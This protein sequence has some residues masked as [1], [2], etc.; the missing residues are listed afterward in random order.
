MIQCK[1]LQIAVVTDCL[2]INCSNQISNN[3]EILF[4]NFRMIIIKFNN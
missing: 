3:S 4:W 2:R 1:R